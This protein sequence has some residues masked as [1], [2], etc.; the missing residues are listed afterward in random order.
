MPP[1]PRSSIRSRCVAEVAL[2]AV[3]VPGADSV[4]AL[5]PHL[6]TVM[7]EPRVFDALRVHC[8]AAEREH[9]WD[10]LA[11]GSIEPIRSRC[12]ELARMRD[13]AA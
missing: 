3:Q 10:V 13:E 6:A 5:G 8:I 12:T 9:H 11:A 2:I 1:P 7:V 4:S